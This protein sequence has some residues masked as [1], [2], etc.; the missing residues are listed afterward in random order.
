MSAADNALNPNG[1][2]ADGEP[3]KPNPLFVRWVS[4]KEGNRIGVPEEWLDAPVGGVLGK[5][6]GVKAAGT[7]GIGGGKMVEEVA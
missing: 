1:T 7:G 3:A 4:T 6:G 2:N 5:A